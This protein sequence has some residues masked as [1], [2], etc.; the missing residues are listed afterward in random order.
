MGTDDIVLAALLKLSV[1]VT[2]RAGRRTCIDEKK[3]TARRHELLKGDS[4]NLVD[5]APIAG[6]RVQ[7]TSTCVIVAKTEVGRPRM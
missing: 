6:L 5:A 2:V 1:L 3:K 7:S 4:R